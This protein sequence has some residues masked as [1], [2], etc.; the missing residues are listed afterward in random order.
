[1]V[2][3]AHLIVRSKLP[4][5]LELH[6]NRINQVDN[7]FPRIITI[8]IR[9]QTLARMEYTEYDY[10]LAHWQDSLGCYSN[11]FVSFIRSLSSDD[12]YAPMAMATNDL[13]GVDIKVVRNRIKFTSVRINNSRMTTAPLLRHRSTVPTATE[14]KIMLL[15][16]IRSRNLIYNNVLLWWPD[17]TDY[18]F[19]KYSGHHYA[20]CVVVVICMLYHLGF[21]VVLL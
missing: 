18:V 16:K 6:L 21:D 20:E 11:H 8:N 13:R 1:M 4:Q 12:T 3:W 9:K 7:F 19:R 17:S 15:E 10:Y 5:R 14:R 2:I